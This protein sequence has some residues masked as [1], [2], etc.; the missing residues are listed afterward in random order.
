MIETVGAVLIAA[1]GA[2]TGVL[3]SL[4]ER[5]GPIRL[6]HWA[7]EAG[8]P[9]LSLRQD[10]VRFEIYRLLLSTLS[11]ISLVAI[12]A[13]LTWLGSAPTVVI[14]ATLAALALIE[15]PSRVMVSRD[16]EGSLRRLTG[17]FRL[18]R[19]LLMP[20]IALLRPLL[21]ARSMERQSEVGEVD[22]ASEGEIAAFISVGQREGI[23]DPEDEVLVKGVVEF[24]DTLVKSVMTPR[25]EVV[26]ASADSTLDE[27]ASLFIESGHSRLPLYRESIDEVVGVLHLRDLMESLRAGAPGEAESLL[28]EPFIVPETKPISELLR[29]FQARH[30]QL[31]VVVDEFGGVAGVV[32]VEDL[33]EEIVGEIADEHEDDELR[34]Q[35]IG[36]GS[37]QIDG[38]LHIEDL[39]TLCEIEIGETSYE[40]V[41]GLVFT[42]LGFLPEVGERLSRYGLDFEVLEMVERRIRTLRVSISSRAASSEA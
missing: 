28:I 22:E 1:L 6:R 20:L 39:E 35:A 24:G 11:R 27:L 2:L 7:E 26:A 32:T 10:R 34:P 12:F 4:L 23:L 13:L 18:M 30:Q 37:W 41:G 31:A 17:W 33:L 16:P 40:T 3:S 36:D 15:L 38:A 42:E 9:L 29:E 19:I 21:P 14:L 5:S 8:E 25:I